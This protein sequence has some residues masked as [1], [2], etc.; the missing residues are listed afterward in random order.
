MITSRQL[1]SASVLAA[2]LLVVAPTFALPVIPGAKGFGM[3]T[4]AGRGGQVYKVTT[5]A[6]T[7]TG[8][9]KACIDATGP[10][11]CVFEVS[12]TIRLSSD[13]V[14]RNRYLTIAG[15]TAPSP[16]IMLRG[17]GILI[18]TSDVL[19]QHLRVRPGDDLAGTTPDNRDALKIEALSTAPISNIVIDHCSF[20]WAIDET[21]S[22]WQN[23][24]NVSIHNSIIGE[25]LND[26]LHSKGPHGYGLLTGPQDGRVSIV[27]NLL[28]HIV[29]RAPLSNATQQVF[30]NNIVYNFSGMATD[31]QGQALMPTSNSVVSN[32][33]LRGPDH[34]GGWRPILLRADA[35]LLPLGSKVY[36]SD[37][38]FEGT[39]ADQWSL[40]SALGGTLN[41]LLYKTS[42]APV[43][44]S[45]LTARPTANSGVYNYVLDTVGARPAD[46]DSA[47]QRIVQ[48]V[49]ER[50]GRIINCVAA[51]GTT[52]CQKNAGGWP[53]LAQNRRTLTLPLNPNGLASSGY[54]NL[55]VWLQSMSALVEG[56]PIAG[57]PGAPMAL[58]VQ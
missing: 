21:V 27:G 18:K 8:S 57:V 40:A 10:R 35:T 31:L 45:G 46:R 11:V 58:L 50:T 37:N 53:V 9:L 2:T 41:L 47:D 13:L 1:I 39:I 36:L 23:W 22:L 49:R 43:W 17:G 5:L 34:T 14:I 55:E 12:G 54:T 15:Q 20:V 26:S 7:G 42:T 4:P 51:D 33:Y 32:V 19:L 52:R 16:G 48:N 3:E 24:D 30:V 38:W 56:R 25:P 29:A 44:V 6:E 28:A